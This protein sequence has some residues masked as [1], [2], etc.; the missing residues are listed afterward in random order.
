MTLDPDLL[1]ILVC[2][3]THLPL[4]MATPEQLAALNLQIGAGHIKDRS[5]NLMTDRLE[6]ALIREDG[7]RLFPIREGIPVLLLSD[8][9]ELN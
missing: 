9:I 2:P 1:K 6:A 8:A 3:E 4:R 7:H 5:G